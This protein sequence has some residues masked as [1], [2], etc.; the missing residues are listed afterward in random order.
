VTRPVV[1]LTWPWIFGAVAAGF[2]GMWVAVGLTGVNWIGYLV[3]P[4]AMI[5]VLLL[6][7]WRHRS[8]RKH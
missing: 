4:V 8:D 7:S 6:F 2:L 1:R 5:I 3:L